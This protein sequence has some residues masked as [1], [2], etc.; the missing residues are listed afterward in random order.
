[1]SSIPVILASLGSF[2]SILLLGVLGYFSLNRALPHLCPPLPTP[3]ASTA[4]E[5]PSS[6]GKQAWQWVSPGD[7]PV[8]EEE[9]LKEAL[10]VTMP[11]EKGEV[12]DLDTPSPLKDK[13]ELPQGTL[14]SAL[15]TELPLE[16][17]RQVQ[18]HLE[19]RVLG[20][21]RKNSLEG[22]PAQETGLSLLLG[23][24]MQSP[25]GNGP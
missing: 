11:F 4:V 15:D 2:L 17:R 6:Q 10:V 25:R 5:F 8:E 22:S 9:S 18:E 1:M 23:D 3:C 13:I 24:H 21:S 20:P 19:T 16:D 12:A 14:E 7:F